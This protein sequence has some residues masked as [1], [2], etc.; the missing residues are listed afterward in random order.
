MEDTFKEQDVL[1]RVRRE[2]YLADGIALP[3]P[4]TAHP[5]EIL[6]DLV[7]APHLLIAGATGTGKSIFLHSLIISLLLRFEPERLRMIIGN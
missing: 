1:R 5:V 3:A 6:L 4:G 2:L 7:R